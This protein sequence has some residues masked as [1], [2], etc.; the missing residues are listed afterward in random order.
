MA[1]VTHEQAGTVADELF[2]KYLLPKAA[3]T[4][5]LAASLVGT[6]LTLDLT[7]WWSPAL[8]LAKWGYLVA[9]GVLLGGLLWKHGFVRP[10]DVDAAA[11]Y[12]AE[13][14]RRFDRIAAGALA[15]LAVSGV[16]LLAVVYADAPLALR[17]GLAGALALT[18]TA[19]AIDTLDDARPRALPHGRW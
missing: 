13:M 9:F 14:Y 15:V 3:L 2:D 1:D 8:A 6:A 11:D 19:G 17:G 12:C 4:V 16:A 10:G 5:I 7:G 18:V